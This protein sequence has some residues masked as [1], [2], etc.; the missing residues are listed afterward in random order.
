MSLTKGINY[1][2]GKTATDVEVTYYA[3]YV[4]RELESKITESH[5]AFIIR[6][7]RKTPELANF[8]Q[9]IRDVKEWTANACMYCGSRPRTWEMDCDGLFENAT[10]DSEQCRAG[11]FGE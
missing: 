5:A 2:P 7:T 8:I 4:S 1:F 11:R 3:Y 6:E 9:V 10:C